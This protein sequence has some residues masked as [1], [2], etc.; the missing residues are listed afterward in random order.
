MTAA[1]NPFATRFI[2]PGCIP[3]FFSAPDQHRCIVAKGDVEDWQVQ[4]VGPHGSG[5][6]T[7]VHHLRPHLFQRFDRID[8]LIVRGPFSIQRSRY[9]RTSK[10]A[11]TVGPV[12]FEADLEAGRAG[13]LI[14]VDGVERL[15]WLQRTL[16]RSFCIG[17]KMGL[18]VTTHR[19]LRGLPVIC[20]TSVDRGRFERI[21][22]H[23]GVPQGIAD[24]ERLAGVYHQN[25]REMLFDLYDQH[26]Q[27]DPKSY[28]KMQSVERKMG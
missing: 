18:I 14:V 20:E 11:Q 1:M 26:A 12:G 13:R 27:H 7:L 10:I 24:F 9:S 17:Q 2:A 5:K 8:Y 16:L 23:L 15:S 25:C 6:T 21:L 22:E 19:R 3:Y 28:P 4:I